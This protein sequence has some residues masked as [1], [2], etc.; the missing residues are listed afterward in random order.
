VK[1]S[2]IFRIKTIALLKVMPMLHKSQ[3]GSQQVH[4]RVPPKLR[5]QE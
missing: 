3:N 2:N 5:K 1:K 4:Q